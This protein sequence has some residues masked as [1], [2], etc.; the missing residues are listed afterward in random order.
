MESVDF[1]G[2]DYD[3]DRLWDRVIGGGFDGPGT[4]VEM[5]EPQLKQGERLLQRGTPV[6]EKKE[7]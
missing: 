5:R 4:I 7:G 2:Q 1:A 3:P 6:V